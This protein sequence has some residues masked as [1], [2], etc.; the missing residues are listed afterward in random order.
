MEEEGYGT[1]EKEKWVAPAIIAG[2]IVLILA[3]VLYEMYKLMFGGSVQVSMEDVYSNVRACTP[4]IILIAVAIVA[5]LAVSIGV[6]RQEEEK[7]SMIRWQSFLAAV[8]VIC[9]AVNWICLGTEYSLLSQVLAD[10]KALSDETRATSKEL[11][12]NIGNEGIVL[13]K[14]ENNSLPVS[15]DTKLNVFGWGSTQPIYGGSGSGDVDESQAVSL[16]QGLKDAGFTLNDSLSEFYT[17]YRSDRPVVGMGE[18]DWTIVQPTME[19]YDD[20]GIFESAKE[21]SDTAVIVL[22]RSGGEG[23]DLPDVYSDECTYNKTQ[24]GGDVVYSTQE[25]DLDSDKSYLELSSREPVSC[26]EGNRRVWQRVRDR[27]FIQSHGAWDGW[28]NMITSM[29]YCGQQARALMA[30]NLWERSC[31]GK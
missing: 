4:Q 24:M 15:T 26:G 16:L 28:T 19:D 11:A 9:V 31:P 12:E 20:A 3:V 25:D 10:A 22:T 29:A 27:Q 2:V 21:F 18:V 30:L 6:K 7:R 5:A 23:M 8:L 14:N 17:E 1:E 13:L